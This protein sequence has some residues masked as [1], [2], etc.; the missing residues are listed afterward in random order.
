[1]RKKRV[2]FLWEVK[3][4]GEVRV[5]ASG[6]LTVRPYDDREVR[7]VLGLKRGGVGR[8]FARLYLCRNLEA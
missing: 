1:M 5:G 3:V 4:V 6:R 7:R 8:Y 2:R